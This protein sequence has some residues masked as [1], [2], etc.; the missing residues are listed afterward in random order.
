[1]E[2]QI[3]EKKKISTFVNYKNFFFQTEFQIF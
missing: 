1:M 2:F 3:F